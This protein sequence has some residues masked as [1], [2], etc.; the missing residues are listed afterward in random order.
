MITGFRFDLDAPVR[1]KRSDVLGRVDARMESKERGQS[2]RVVTRSRNGVGSDRTW[3]SACEIEDALE[4][5]P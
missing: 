2:F 4:V 5:V 1:V 3:Y